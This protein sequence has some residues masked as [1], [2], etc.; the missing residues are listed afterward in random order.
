MHKT[1][2]PKILR[3]PLARYSHAVETAP[4]LRFVLCSG[5]L[6]IEAS[7]AVPEGAE[8]QSDLCFAAI[9]VILAEAGMGMGD[10]VRLNAYVT[11]ADYLADYMRSRD[12]H[13]VSPP[14]ASTLM[15]V[16][17][18]ARPEFKVEVEVIAAAP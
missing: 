16:S 3:S 2:N 17:G 11:S 13:V 10:V 15:I 14:P 1:I 4:N 8:T 9:S 6:G 5:Q 18:F 12:R 7:G